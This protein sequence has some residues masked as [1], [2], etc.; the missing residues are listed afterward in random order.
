MNPDEGGSYVIDKKGNRKL[1]EQTRHAVVAYT[2]KPLHNAA[3]DLKEGQE[4]DAE[5]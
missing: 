2:E 4:E 1:V 5:A 3:Q